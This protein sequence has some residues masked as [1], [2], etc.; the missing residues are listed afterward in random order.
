MIVKLSLLVVLLPCF[1]ILYV[2]LLVLIAHVFSLC[3]GT[4]KSVTGAHLAYVFAKFNRRFQLGL[5]GP[6]VNRCVL[7]CA[8]SNK[9]VD[10]VLGKHS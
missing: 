3:T 2:P 8:P 7:Y 10:V 1:P 9:A 5:K 6:S 4:G